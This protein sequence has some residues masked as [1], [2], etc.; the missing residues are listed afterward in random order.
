MKEKSLERG[1]DVTAT[2]RLTIAL[3]G[4]PECVYEVDFAS[5]ALAGDHVTYRGSFT[6]PRRVK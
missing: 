4:K 5:N 6:G 1:S 2:Y 3:D